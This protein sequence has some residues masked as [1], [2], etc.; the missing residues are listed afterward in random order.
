MVRGG[1]L[2][3]AL[4][5]NYSSYN[6]SSSEKPIFHYII[7]ILIIATL[8]VSTFALVTVNELK[9]VLIPDTVDVNDFLSKL[10]SHDQMK[11]YVG[12]APLNIIQVSNDNIANLQAQINGLDASYIGDFIIQYTDAVVIYDYKGDNV[13]GTVSLQ[14]PQQA[15]LPDD[16]NSKLYSHPELQGL[17]NE[18]PIGGQIDAATLNTLKQQFPE[19]YANTKVGDFLLRYTTKL[20]IYDYNANVVVNSINLG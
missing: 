11:A 20:I 5:H 10:T 8:A 15:Q 19:I 7:I 4:G 9:K 1:S 2:K 3:S 13:K 14:Q 12:V 16:F 18:Q 6:A 17:E